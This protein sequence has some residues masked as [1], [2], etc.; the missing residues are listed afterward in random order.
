VW[1]ALDF[2]ERPQSLAVASERA[3]GSSGCAVGIAEE[4][5]GVMVRCAECA[6]G[7]NFGGIDLERM[8]SWRSRADLI[9]RSR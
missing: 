8:S 6:S 3:P 2:G 9:Y 4:A 7:R 1:R 5:A